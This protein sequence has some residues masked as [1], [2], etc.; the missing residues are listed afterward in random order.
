MSHIVQ[1]LIWE[2]GTGFSVKKAIQQ[3]KDITGKYFLVIEEGG[4]DGDPSILIASDEKAKKVLKLKANF[5][6]IKKII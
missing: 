6:K 5:S 2:N 4:R 1:S 3:V